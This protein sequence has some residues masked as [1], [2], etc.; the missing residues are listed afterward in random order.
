[1]YFKFKMKKI[2]V[3]LF[4]I[5]IILISTVSGKIIYD[6]D[7]ILLTDRDLDFYTGFIKQNYN[8]TYNENIALKKLILIKLLIKKIKNENPKYLKRLDQNINLIEENS[9]EMDINADLQR[10]LL[11]RKEL[12]LEYY[13]N[14]ITID[15]IRESLNELQTF[16]IGLSS[17]NCL[18][19]DKTINF[20]N[21]TNFPEYYLNK[22][23]KKNN[24]KLIFEGLEVCL[25]SEL[26]DE[27]EMNLYNKLSVKADTKINKII[28]D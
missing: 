23:R 4:F 7:E 11:L 28:Y 12:I 2:C 19:L 5:F 13:N 9:S 3:Y 8:I 6:K 16:K 24:D 14:E 10:Y 18:F 17:S 26:L 27:F 21:I 22:I 20:I 15:D 1:M 25:N